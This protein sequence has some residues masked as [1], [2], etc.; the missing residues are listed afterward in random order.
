MGS[1]GIR[2]E[3]MWVQVVYIGETRIEGVLAN[4]PRRRNDLRAGEYVAFTR[5]EVGDY[6]L[7]TPDGGFEGNALKALTD[8]GFG[9]YAPAVGGT[10]TPP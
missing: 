1:R 7:T 10:S 2:T 8:R 6:H 9:L 3:W 5:D 4:E